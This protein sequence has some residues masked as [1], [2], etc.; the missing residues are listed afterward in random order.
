[1]IQCTYANAPIFTV[2]SFGHTVRRAMNAD[3]QRDLINS[4]FRGIGDTLNVRFWL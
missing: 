3:A 4:P 1:M 2:I